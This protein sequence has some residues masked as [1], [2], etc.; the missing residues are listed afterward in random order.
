VLADAIPQGVEL[1]LSRSSSS[2][3]RC[4]R[5]IQVVARILGHQDE[6]VELEVQGRSVP[7]L[8][9]LDQ[10]H[11]QEGHDVVLVLMRACQVSE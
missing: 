10:E 1:L 5:W 9:V 4:S 2:S 8:R 3:E 6:L 7:V 11:D